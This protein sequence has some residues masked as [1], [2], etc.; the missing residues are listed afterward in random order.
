MIEILYLVAA[1]AFMVGLKQLGHP[2]TARSGNRLASIGMLLAIVVT[3]VSEDIINWGTLIAGLVLGAA[4]RS[5]VR[6]QSPNDIDAANGGRL[7]R[8]RRH[9]FSAG[10]GGGSHRKWNRRRTSRNKHFH[11]GF[12]GHR[13]DHVHRQFHCVRQASRLASGAAAGVLRSTVD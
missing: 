2:R 9:C 8:I 13:C 4:D 1:V 5:M 3:L 6:G 12:D 10:G 11:S 7:Q